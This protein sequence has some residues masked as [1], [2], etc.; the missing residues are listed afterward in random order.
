MKTLCR[1]LPV[2]FIL[3]VPS[4]ANVTVTTPTAGSSV[5]SPVHYVASATTSCAQGVA[6][7]GIYVNNKLIYVVSGAQLNTTISLSTGP[8]HTVVEEWDHCGG[9][10]YT[11]IDLTVV[12]PPVTSV[13]IT[14][15]PLTITAGSST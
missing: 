2:L 6:S 13:T 15:N 10:T 12:P 14:A 8:E 5:T 9:A 1:L 4:L 3:P 7:M 11:T